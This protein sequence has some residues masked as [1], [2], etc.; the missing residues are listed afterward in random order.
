M[1]DFLEGILKAIGE[2]FRPWLESWPARRVAILFMIAL[3]VSAIAVVVAAGEA[4]VAALIIGGLMSGA[5]GV[6]W[7]GA[8]YRDR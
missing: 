5:I 7:F 6:W 4:R 1:T 8:Y 3:L 2:M